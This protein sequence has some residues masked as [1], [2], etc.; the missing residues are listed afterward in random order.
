MDAYLALFIFIFLF[1]SVFVYGVY[2]LSIFTLLFT[3][4]IGYLYYSAMIGKITNKELFEMS[5]IPVGFMLAPIV[6]IAFVFGKPISMLL[7]QGM[8][9]AISTRRF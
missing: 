3:G 7:L 5:L 1:S 6:L 2:R 4:T 9:S 8:A